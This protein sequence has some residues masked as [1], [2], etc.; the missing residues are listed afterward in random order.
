MIDI[1]RLNELVLAANDIRLNVDPEA[2][3]ISE[4]YDFGCMSLGESINHFQQC[5]LTEMVDRTHFRVGAH[6]LMSEAVLMGNDNAE[7]LFEAAKDTAIQAWHRFIDGVKKFVNGI[8]AKARERSTLARGQYVEWIKIVEPK[9]VDVKKYR[10]AMKRTTSQAMPIYDLDYMK[11]GGEADMALQHILDDLIKAKDSYVANVKSISAPE[12]DEETDQDRISKLQQ[13]AKDLNLDD[14]SKVTELQHI[15]DGVYKKCISDANET[16]RSYDDN[17]LN[18]DA[19]VSAIKEIPEVFTSI[20][21]V[22]TKELANIDRVAKEAEQVQAQAAQS[23]TMDGRPAVDAQAAVAQ[24]TNAFQDRFSLQIQVINQVNAVRNSICNK[25][26][27]DYSQAVAEFVRYRD[28]DMAERKKAEREQR[29]AQREKEQQ[30]RQAN[31]TANS[32]GTV[33]Y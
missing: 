2:S 3:S 1:F 24:K 21:E 17:R 7:L 14:P 11:K 28:P 32:G 23:T 15:V 19:M 20:S 33:A 5:L 29:R 10:D 18:V 8:I 26:L 13:Y 6:Q 22:Y 30:T 16:V 31:R 12:N 27:A 4:A 9:V 25:C